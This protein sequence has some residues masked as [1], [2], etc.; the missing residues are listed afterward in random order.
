MK[1]IKN[2]LT[3]L[4]TLLLICL[5]VG[6]IGISAIKN[7]LNGNEEIS[8]IMNVSA[9][10]M[11]PE[12]FIISNEIAHKYLDEEFQHRNIP[13][14]LIDYIIEN[15]EFK[16]LVVDYKDSYI[17]YVKGSGE[18]PSIPT[19]Q[20]YLVIESETEKYNQDTGNTFDSAILKEQ[21]ETSISQIE[22]QVSNV[23]SN[24]LVSL[25]LKIL[26]NKNL[27]TYFIVALAFVCILLFLLQKTHGFIF[28]SVANI[29]SGF[30]VILISQIMNLSRFKNIKEI[31][32]NVYSSIKNSLLAY[33]F[34]TIIIGI[35]ISIIPI[36]IY[37]SKKGSKNHD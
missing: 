18:K 6:L 35:L 4:F 13:T 11:I 1:I 34:I 21:V 27:T 37:F 28:L 2:I 16:E 19:E 24:K 25:G 20:V 8:F 9:E 7:G 33:G 36:C 17:D 22:N 31:L 15:E 3:I 10:E 26:N 30:V 5:L 14:Q 32:G 23:S 12:N 29:L